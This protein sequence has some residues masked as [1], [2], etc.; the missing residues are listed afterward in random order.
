MTA[1][2]DLR[3]RIAI[4]VESARSALRVA[5]TYREDRERKVLDARFYLRLARGLRDKLVAS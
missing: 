5:R 2:D 3:R 4:L 1:Q